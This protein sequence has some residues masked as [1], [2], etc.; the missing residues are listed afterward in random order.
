MGVRCK[1]FVAEVQQRSTWF[2][3]PDGSMSVAQESEVVKLQPA[4]GDAN[5]GWSKWTP[6]G[7]IDL[8]INNPDAFGKLKVGQ[9]YFVDFTEAPAAEKDEGK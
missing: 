7:A 9:H 6:G 8:Q 5:K 1:F 2:G 4:G 3:R